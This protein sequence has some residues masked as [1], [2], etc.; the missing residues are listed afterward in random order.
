MQHLPLKIK[1]GTHRRNPCDERKDRRPGH[2]RHHRV[3]VVGDLRSKHRGAVFRHRRDLAGPRRPRDLC[4]A[5]RDPAPVGAVRGASL[6]GATHSVRKSIRVRVDLTH[7]IG[8]AGRCDRRAF[9]SATSAPVPSKE[10]EGVDG[11]A[12]TTGLTGFRP[13]EPKVTRWPLLVWRA[14]EGRRPA[15]IEDPHGR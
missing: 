8:S 6:C 4:F 13:P 14:G 1:E 15:G 10:S 9:G 3:A 12:G 2:D 7:R 11:T 5:V